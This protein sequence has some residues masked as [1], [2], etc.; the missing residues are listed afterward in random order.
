MSE[1]NAPSLGQARQ[2]RK[3]SLGLMAAVLLLAGL[4][5]AGWHWV[6]GRHQQS[7]DNAYVAGHVVQITPQVAGTVVAVQADDTDAVRAGQPLVQLDA[8]D[9]RLALAQAEAELGRTVREV[10]GLFAAASALQPQVAVRAAE[11]SRAQTEQ[12]RAQDDVN[13][14]RP[15]VE[16]GAVG[17][18]EFQH[19][20][21][22]LT[23]ARSSVAAAQAALASAR[24]QLA[25][26][27]VQT[28]GLRPEEH[29]AVLR[30]VARVREAWLGTQRTTLAAPVAGQVARRAVQ[31]GQR[32]QPGTPLMTV[33][34]LDALW[35]DA[36]FKESQ[37]HALRVG[38]R[39]TLHADVHGSKVAYSGRVVGL[40][41]GTGAAFALLPAQNAT[42][43]WIKIVQRVPVRIALDTKEVAAHPL[44]IGLSMEVTVDTSEQAG[45]PV[46]AAATAPAVARTT[47]FEAQEAQADAAVAR[48]LQAHLGRSGSAGRASSVGLAPV[49]R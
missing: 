37:L 19:M 25:A 11:L 27:Q 1:A 42:G 8:A 30:A 16:S 5:Y 41:A 36:N 34:A 43:N 14:R 17:R 32:V 31:L 13:R 35:V 15:L 4:A 21:A 38:Q 6:A 45:A 47:V 44:R 23:A 2:A 28:E 48:I 18:E 3:R 26:T 12:A 49:R 24:E 29:P 9:A 7:T 10:R 40:G 20:Q 39:A 22:Q 33:V 46:A